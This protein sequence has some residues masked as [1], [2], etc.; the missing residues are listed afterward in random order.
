MCQSKC[1]L[2]AAP[3]AL[4]ASPVLAV[5]EEWTLATLPIR[6]REEDFLLDPLPHALNKLQESFPISVVAGGL[7]SY[8][9][10]ILSLQEHVQAKASLPVEAEDFGTQRIAGKLYVGMDGIV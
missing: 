3:S 7:I 9:L 10:R 5:I 6:F 2:I 8:Q 1:S 4:M